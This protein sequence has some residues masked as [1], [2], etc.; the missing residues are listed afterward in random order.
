MDLQAIPPALCHWIDAFDSASPDLEDAGPFLKSFIFLTPHFPGLG[1]ADMIHVLI[2]TLEVYLDDQQRWKAFELE[3]YG[4]RRLLRHLAASMR[5]VAKAILE[6]QPL[7]RFERNVVPYFALLSTA[8][9]FPPVPSCK[10]GQ[11]NEALLEARFASHHNLWLATSLA[12]SLHLGMFCLFWLG[13][14]DT[15]Y[16]N[17]LMQGKTLS[18]E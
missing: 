11:V 13:L 3:Q 8:S 5:S 18:E 14:L 17:V 2:G 15:Q 10:C 6:K 12:C 16:C 9:R 7:L 1:Y 4:L